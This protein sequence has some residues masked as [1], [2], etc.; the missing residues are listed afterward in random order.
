MI[1]TRASEKG[2]RRKLGLPRSWGAVPIFCRP[3]PF[4]ALNGVGSPSTSMPSGLRNVLRCFAIRHSAPCFPRVTP[5]T[6]LNAVKVHKPVILNIRRHHASVSSLPNTMGSQFDASAQPEPFKV[7]VLGGCYAGL[8]AA[9]NLIDLSEGRAARQGNGVVP[10]HDG[11]I[12][13]DITI[14]D[15]RDG[16]CTFFNYLSWEPLASIKLLSMTKAST[17]ETS[18]LLGRRENPLSAKIPPSLHLKTHPADS[19][20]RPPHRLSPSPRR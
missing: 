20:L 9:L 18:G 11:K 15:E 5:F 17:R 4:Y 2:G 1:A 7:L 10:A 12:P 6:P 14:V 13:V 19:E 8:S 16:Y 3:I